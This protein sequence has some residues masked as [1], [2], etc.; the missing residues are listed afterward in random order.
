M[1]IY[2]LMFA[3]GFQ[4]SP[5]HYASAAEFQRSRGPGNASS[6]RQFYKEMTALSADPALNGTLRLIS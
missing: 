2:G 6:L 5:T 3:I 1:I 4:H